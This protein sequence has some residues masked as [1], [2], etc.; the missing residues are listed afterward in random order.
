MTLKMIID[1]N[2]IRHLLDK[3][4]NAES[5]PEEENL[6]SRIASSYCSADENINRELKTFASIQSALLSISQE[7]EEIPPHINERLTRHIE[8]LTSSH[9]S[10][11]NATTGKRHSRK[12][13]ILLSLSAAAAVILLL[14]TGLMLLNLS[15]PGDNGKDSRYVSRDISCEST[16]G[17]DKGLM[18][19]ATCPPDTI[20]EKKSHPGKFTSTPSPRLSAESSAPKS[21]TPPPPSLSLEDQLYLLNDS[22]G[23]SPSPLLCFN[24]CE[25]SDHPTFTEMAREG[26]EQV[27]TEM[28]RFYDSANGSIHRVA[29]EIEIP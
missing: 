22:L 25:P 19:A 8:E 29:N 7:C 24:D 21:V 12:R 6:L 28:E 1:D 14:S 4:Y 3:Y 11:V 10:I 2:R 5:S 18:S 17:V 13:F 9:T 20:S 16:V 15:T 26:I 27:N 23:V